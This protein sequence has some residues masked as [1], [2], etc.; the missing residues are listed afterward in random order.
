MGND[1]VSDNEEDFITSC[2][3]CYKGYIFDFIINECV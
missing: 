3:L 1:E 2:S